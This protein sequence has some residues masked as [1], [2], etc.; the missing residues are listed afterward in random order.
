KKING[1]LNTSSTKH[2]FFW[3]FESRGNPQKDPFLLWLNG[4]PGCSSMT[5]LFMELGPC[6]VDRQGKSVSFNRNSWNKHAN[7]LFLDQPISSGYSYGQSRV[8]DS[9]TAIEEVYEFLQLFFTQFNEYAPLDF[10]IAGESYAG[11]YIPPLATLITRENRKINDFSNLFHRKMTPHSVVLKLKSIAIGNGMVDPLTQYKSFSQ[12]ACK[13]SY[14]PVLTQTACR[15]MDEAY[16]HCAQLIKRC[17]AEK[18]SYYCEE[19]TTKC[20]EAMLVPF[21]N[22]GK[23]VYDVRKECKGGPLCYEHMYAVEQYLRK[24]EVIRA[25][26]SQI[27][28]F[29]TCN[30]AVNHRF[31]VNGDW[32]KPYHASVPR[33]LDEGIRVLLYAG[34][35][36]Y[37]CNWI[38]YKDWAK[39]IAWSQQ[40]EF[41]RAFDIPWISK[42][43]GRIAGEIRQTRNGRLTFLKMYKAGHMVPYDQPEHSLDMI[44]AWTQGILGHRL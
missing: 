9:G 7:I 14:A 28:T 43:T 36:D 25:S 34:D 5:G 40:N 39:S 38:G 18:D 12:M 30:S 3:F 1:Y 27:T 2:F 41:N 11:H 8:S 26:H 21:M 13:N 4:G 33:L 24:P 23:S 37:I 10:H 42:S 16:P 44:H 29:K 20:N 17:Y 19:A 22:T 32:M 35:A 6:L 31:V 15:K